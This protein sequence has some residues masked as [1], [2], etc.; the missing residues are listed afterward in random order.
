MKSQQSMDRCRQDLER[1]CIRV[2]EHEPRTNGE[3][4]RHS[5]GTGREDA[6]ATQTWVSDTRAGR[7]RGEEGFAVP[8]FL[9]LA[10]DLSSLRGG[11]ARSHVRRP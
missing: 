1:S 3:K 7:A 8:H 2:R 11:P 6:V 9:A 5:Q 10:S 4:D